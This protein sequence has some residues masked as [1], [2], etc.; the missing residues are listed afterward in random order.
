MVVLPVMIY[1]HDETI[2]DYGTALFFVKNFR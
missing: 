1:H 2:K